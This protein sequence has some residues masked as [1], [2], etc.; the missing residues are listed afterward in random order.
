MFSESSGWSDDV[1][2]MVRIQQSY[3]LCESSCPILESS[4][5]IFAYGV[6]LLSRYFPAYTVSI[7]SL[8]TW[9]GKMIRG[10]LD[11]STAA[12]SEGGQTYKIVLQQ[13]T[14]A[15]LCNAIDRADAVGLQDS[16][17]MLCFREVACT[18]GLEGVVC[19]E[20]YRQLTI[21]EDLANYHSGKS[22]MLKFTFEHSLAPFEV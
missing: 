7:H 18:K 8:K 13:Q 12:R 5:S 14:F 19:L 22:R 16:A 11:E 6:K 9:I 17:L 1:V 3:S 21:I 2:C 10:Y 4:L 15:P 20:V